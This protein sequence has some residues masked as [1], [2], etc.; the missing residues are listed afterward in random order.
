MY[1]AICGNN[2]IQQRIILAPIG[3]LR[4]LPGIQKGN[5]L[6][7]FFIHLKNDLKLEPNSGDIYTY[8]FALH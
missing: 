5:K 4:L 1:R 8:S 6:I 7:P 2:P 3:L